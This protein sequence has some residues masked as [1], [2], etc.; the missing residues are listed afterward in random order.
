MNDL[1]DVLTLSNYSGDENMLIKSQGR[2]MRK[3]HAIYSTRI[4]DRNTKT[5]EQDVRFKLKQT[6]KLHNMLYTNS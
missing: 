3:S 6:K 5:S 4:G 2:I 1:A